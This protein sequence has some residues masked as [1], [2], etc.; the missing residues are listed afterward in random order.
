MSSRGRSR[1]ANGTSRQGIAKN[2]EGRSHRRCRHRGLQPAA[3]WMQ[4]GELGIGESVSPPQAGVRL[5]EWSSICTL[6]SSLE[7]NRRD[8]AAVREP[9]TTLI[10]FF[11]SVTTDRA[12]EIRC[13]RVRRIFVSSP[14]LALL[15]ESSLVVRGLEFLAIGGRKRPHP[16]IWKRS[17]GRLRWLL[18]WR[19]DPCVAFACR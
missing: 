18:D 19:T 4:A 7:W 8:C 9:C 16:H 5:Q 10:A 11:L 17:V 14:V 1:R 3:C 6:P 2:E 13:A 15:H 12:L